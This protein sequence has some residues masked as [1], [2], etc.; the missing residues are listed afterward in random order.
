MTKVKRCK[1]GGSSDKRTVQVLQHFESAE[2]IDSSR[3]DKLPVL[4]YW[5]IMFPKSG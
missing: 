2:V 4:N 1:V 5:P 3:R